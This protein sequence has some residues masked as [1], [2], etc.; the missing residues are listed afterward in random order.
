MNLFCL[1]KPG[2]QHAIVTIY[3]NNYTF[4]YIYTMSCN[5]V[6][7]VRGVVNKRKD[8]GYEVECHV[9]T[10]ILNCNQIS[11]EIILQS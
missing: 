2:L 6:P 3:C 5:L 1:K 4:N 11:I 9:G 8:P 10:N 7:G